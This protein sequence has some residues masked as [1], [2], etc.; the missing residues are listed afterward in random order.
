MML[1]SKIEE[2]AHIQRKLDQALL[3]NQLIM[4][5]ILASNPCGQVSNPQMFASSQQTTAADS[6]ANHQANLYGMPAQVVQQTSA[7]APSSGNANI[8]GLLQAFMSQKQQPASTTGAFVPV[9]TSPKSSANA[10]AFRTI[11]LNNSSEDTSS[12]S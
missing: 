10:P 4:T 11:I 1:Y 6:G 12:L 9:S 2:N 3:Q 8:L 7:P 5:Q